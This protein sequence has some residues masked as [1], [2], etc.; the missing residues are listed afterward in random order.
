VVV[1]AVQKTGPSEK[2]GLVVIK[3]SRP[4]IESNLDEARRNEKSKKGGLAYSLGSIFEFIYSVPKLIEISKDAENLKKMYKK[5]ELK[6]EIWNEEQQNTANSEKLNAIQFQLSVQ[7]SLKFV[8]REAFF[9]LQVEREDDFAPIKQLDGDEATPEAA[10]RALS[11]LHIKYL[12]L[13]GA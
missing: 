12:A 4:C 9:V 8:D 5:E 2:I 7:E 1:K 13:A 11:D 10:T 6:Q 3:D